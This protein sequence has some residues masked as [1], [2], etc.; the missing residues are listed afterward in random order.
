MLLVISHLIIIKGLITR[1]QDL[2]EAAAD[3]R[4]EWG[5]MPARKIFH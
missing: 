5:D 2:H 1:W 3:A 4:S